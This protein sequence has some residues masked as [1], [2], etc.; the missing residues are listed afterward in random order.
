MTWPRMC[1][2]TIGEWLAILFLVPIHWF[3]L[4]PAYGW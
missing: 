3:N 1:V 4:R 2:H